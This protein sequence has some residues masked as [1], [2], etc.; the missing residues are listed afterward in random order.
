MFTDPA[1]VRQGVGRAILDACEAAARAAGFSEAEMMATLAGEPLY[2]TCGYAV[3]ER[4]QAAPVD[5]VA[6][7][8]VR[9][10]KKLDG[11]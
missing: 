4:M 1:F 5:G 2:R 3:V 10:R 7:P 8:L 11:L 6:V 9:M